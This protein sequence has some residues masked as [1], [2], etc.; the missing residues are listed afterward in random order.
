MT[1]PRTRTCF[2]AGAGPCPCP[3]RQT[4]GARSTAQRSALMVTL[5]WLADF[6]L[7]H[8]PFQQHQ[9]GH[10][11]HFE[12][13]VGRPHHFEGQLVVYVPIVQTLPHPEPHV[14]ELGKSF[15]RLEIHPL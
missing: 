12:T 14:D 13:A 4:S 10:H 8:L 1:N 7:A 6:V 2:S 3:W 11:F 5:I 9:G 15:I